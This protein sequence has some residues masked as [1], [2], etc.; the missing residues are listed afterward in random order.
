MTDV[1]TVGVKFVIGLWALIVGFVFPVSSASAHDPIILTQEQTEPASGPLVPD[2][3]ISFAFYG[4]VDG[5]GDT[6]AFRVNFTEGDRLFLS[7][8]IPDLSPENALRD[9]QLP[10]L[11]L[12]DPTGTTTI[13]RPDLRLPFPEPFSGTNYVRLLDLDSTAVA[14]EYAVTVIGTA[15]ARFT[16]SVGFKEVFGTPVEG[17]VDRSLG[18]N[19]VMDW[20]A[21]PPPDEV[22]SDMVTTTLPA[23]TSPNSQ[24]SLVDESEVIDNENSGPTSTI[25]WVLAVVAA[26][27][28]V[29]LLFAVRAASVR[30]SNHSNSS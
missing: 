18:V 19:G 2:G 11:E 8:L 22:T 14:G 30:Y 24:V 13:L 20:Y 7:L 9:D 10:Y 21:T 4:V 27:A 3:T 23:T 15:P 28:I 16:V 29:G 17:V 26:L 6:R 5:R 12:V 1:Q 25:N